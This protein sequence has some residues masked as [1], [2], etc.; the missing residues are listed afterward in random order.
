MKETPAGG[1]KALLVERLFSDF[2]GE[3]ARVLDLGCGTAVNF[4]PALAR[5]PN[6]AYTGVDQDQ[7][8]LSKARATVGRLP[9]VALYEGFGEK[10]QGHE[11]DLVISLSVVEH[12]KRLDRFLAVS[13]QAA[14]EGGRV[15]HRYDLGHALSPSSLG[16]RLR[17]A[18]ATKVP[19][20]V[21][22]SRFTT[23]PDLEAIVSQLSELGVSGI[24]ITQSQMPSLKAAMNLLEHQR[25]DEASALAKRI[26]NL[27]KALW[28]H[29]GT[30]LEQ[31]E[32]DRL[33]PSVM[34]S[35]YRGTPWRTA[36]SALR[37]DHHD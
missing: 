24:T 9:N 28:T 17:V 27:D 10:F 21:P 36:A 6:I 34:V 7:R 30:R 8:A 22:K 15:V 31:K 1:Y 25:S 23:H 32:R 14:R 2:A 5:H 16:E 12:V 37:A 20:V 13:V 35:G 33:F 4:E 18:V 3:P 19:I 26:T 29:F 11:F